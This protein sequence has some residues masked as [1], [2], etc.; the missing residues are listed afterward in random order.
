[1]P[2]LPEVEIIAR[3]LS[4]LILSKTVTSIDSI[5]PMLNMKTQDILNKTIEN[6]RRKGKYLFW[7]F[8]DRS[9]L[10]VHMGMT[11]RLIYSEQRENLRYQRALVNLSQGFVSF[12][13]SRRF[14]KMKYLLPIEMEIFINSLGI[15]PLMID[16]TWENFER[17]FINKNLPIK[18][19]LMNQ[20]W[21]AGIGN[22]YAN[23]ILILSK[24]YPEKRVSDLSSAEKK[25]LFSLI[26]IVLNQAIYCQGTTIRDY[27]HTD[28]STGFF[29]N[30][31]LVYGREGQPCSICQTP[32]R[33]FK[34]SQRSTYYCPN[35]QKK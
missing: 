28:G 1:M 30:C 6:I 27:Q 19:F 13:D 11:G 8:D 4:P 32:I 34:M 3:E 24:I 20:S 18:N 23:E 17:L 35:C 7:V 21:V 2:E 14:G 16:Y 9:S 26:P 29:Q 15:D 5:D 33:R 25:T 10:L 22:I 12:C 31:L